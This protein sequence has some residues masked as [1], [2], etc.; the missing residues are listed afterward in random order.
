MCWAT[1]RAGLIGTAPGVAWWV[2][3]VWRTGAASA[4][5]VRG[6]LG[7]VGWVLLFAGGAREYLG[8]LARPPYLARSRRLLRSACAAFS[9]LRNLGL[10]ADRVV[11]CWL[12][13]RCVAFAGFEISLSVYILPNSTAISGFATRIGLKG[14][15]YIFPGSQSD[16]ARIF[17]CC[18]AVL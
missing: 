14:L 2:G 7:A 9:R 6:R 10:I 8:D 4:V 17:T 13:S 11:E 3:C 16:K 18:V 5:W 1:R 15:R 12:L